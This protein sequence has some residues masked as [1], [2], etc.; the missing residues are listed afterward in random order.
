MSLPTVAPAAT[1][2]PAPRRSRTWARVA[3]L[4]V[5][6]ALV[7][8]GCGGTDASGSD[9]KGKPAEK[10]NSSAAFPVSIKHA[11]GT[12]EIPEKPKRIVAVSWMNQDIVAALGVLPVG[13][14]KQWGGDKDGHT[15]WFRTQAE[16][17]GGKLPETLNYGDSGEMDFE[18]IL[19]LDPDLIIGLYSGITDVDYKRLTEIAPTIPYLKRPFDG[20]TWQDMTR[21]IGKAL[22]ENEKAEALVTDTEGVL[23]GVVKA[24]PQFKGKTFTYG[25]AL[26]PGSTEAGLY[27]DY[28]PRVRLL[29]EIGFVNTPSMKVITDGVKGTNFYGGVSLEKLDTVKAD[30]FVGWAYDPKEVPYSLNDPLFKRWEPIEKK[31]YAFVETAEL[32][33]AVSAPTVL[34]IPWAMERYAPLLADAVAGKGRSDAS[35][36]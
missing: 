17:L 32:G 5:A 25:T 26:T 22:G 33:M 16:K 30:V 28:D 11:H 14:D 20:G 13:V 18:Q 15:P 10:Q 8:T 31:Q 21:T 7:L 29:T 6:A 2:A 19:S 12:T 34:S 1:P 36:S 35:T 23:A 27:V 24:N 4:A 3:G 9:G